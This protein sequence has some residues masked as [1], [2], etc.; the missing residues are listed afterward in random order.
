MNNHQL[1]NDSTS[2]IGKKDINKSSIYN[3][4]FSKNEEIVKKIPLFEEKFTLTKKKTE[5]TQLILEKKLITS[6]KIEIPIKY[7]D[8]YQRQRI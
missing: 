6:T 2:K 1:K 5:E 7:E 8:I 4:T 3:N